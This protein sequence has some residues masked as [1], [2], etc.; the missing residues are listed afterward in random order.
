MVQIPN[1]LASLYT[2]VYGFDFG[3]MHRQR[4][5][6][7]TARRGVKS[8]VDDSGMLYYVIRVTPDVG[9]VLS[10]LADAEKRA[11]KPF[12]IVS[13]MYGIQTEPHYHPS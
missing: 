13:L 1:I 7:S 2:D 10:P 5:Y 4:M 6:V 12:F 8:S 3:N 9:W 11:W